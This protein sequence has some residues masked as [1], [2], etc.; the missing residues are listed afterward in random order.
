MDQ[1][2]QF[3]ARKIPKYYDT[4]SKQTS[5]KDNEGVFELF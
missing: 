2:S 4:L 3:I 1:V 5:A